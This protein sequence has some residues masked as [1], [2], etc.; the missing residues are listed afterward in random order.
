LVWVEVVV[1]E[2]VRRVLG[3]VRAVVRVPAGF[4][5]V[6]RLVVAGLGVPGVLVDMALL[7]LSV[8]VVFL[9]HMFVHD[10]LARVTTGLMNTL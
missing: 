1:R 3:A 5:L 4:L 2:L 8:R 10:R 6:V 9:E 7:L